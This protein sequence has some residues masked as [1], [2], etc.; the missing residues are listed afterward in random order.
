MCETWDRLQ[1]LIE[2]FPGFM[3]PDVSFISILVHPISHVRG[4][5]IHLFLPVSDAE[6]SRM[7]QCPPDRTYSFLPERLIRPWRNSWCR[8]SRVPPPLVLPF[9]LPADNPSGESSRISKERTTSNENWRETAIAQREK[10][11]KRCL[12][13]P[14]LQWGLQEARE[15]EEHDEWRGKRPLI[16]ESVP[17]LPCQLFCKKSEVSS[18]SLVQVYSLGGREKSWDVCCDHHQA[19]EEKTRRLENVRSRVSGIA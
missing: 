12:P 2:S 18:D 5:A 8:N 11:V 16:C 4:S 10:V 3:F 19:V 1:N 7:T 13:P 15:R 17:S 14:P 6:G 9:P